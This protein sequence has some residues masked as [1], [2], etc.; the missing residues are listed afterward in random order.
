MSAAAA[1]PGGKTE[2][3]HHVD[4]RQESPDTDSLGRHDAADRDLWRLAFEHADSPIVVVDVDGTVVHANAAAKR[5]ARAS[6]SS[7]VMG[8]PFLEL[9][10]AEYRPAASEAWKQHAARRSAAMGDHESI[11]SVIGAPNFGVSI[12]PLPG[13][14]LF[15][16]TLFSAGKLAAPDLITNHP[17][18][19]SVVNE[20]SQL[21]SQ[22][23]DL[24]QRLQLALEKSLAALRMDAGAIALVDGESRDLVIRAHQ[25][26]EH[27]DLAAR[28]QYIALD[29]SIW[30]QTVHS[31]QVVV[32]DQ[33]TTDT[34]IEPQ[35][36]RDE[37]VD[38]IALAPMF[39]RGQVVGVL[40]VMH[41]QPYTFSPGDRHLLSVVADRVGLAVDNARLYT[42]I[43]RRLQEQSA[44]H[45]IALATQGVLSLQT[46]MDQGLRA[47]TA[48]FNLDAAAVSLL[49]THDRLIPV[50]IHG[51]ETG[52]WD[53][54]QRRRPHLGDTL[55]G[56][57]TTQ[58]RSLIVQNVATS[59]DM[60][61]DDFVAT[62][63]NSVA[64]V[65]LV[66][67][68]RLIGTLEMG[69]KRANALTP[70]DIPLLE[71]LAAQLASAI[72]AARLYEQTERRVDNLTTLTQISA[73]VNR[74][75]NL[76]GILNVVLDETLA[77]VNP[78]TDAPKGAIL[79]V[80]PNSAG[81][82]V[83]VARN[84]D[85]GE[86]LAELLAAT[87]I[88]GLVVRP[89]TLLRDLLAECEIRAYAP[90]AEAS[91]S[92]LWPGEP[93][94]AI[95]MCLDDRSIGTI[96]AIGQPTSGEMERLLEAV[97]DLA[98]VA[99]DKANL[100]EETRR[101]LDEVSLLHE[102]G[103]AAASALDHTA[104]AS[105]AL[106]ALE[107]TSGFE[108]AS[109]LL[110]AADA[111]HLEIVASSFDGT[112]G[113][114]QRALRIGEGITGQTALTGR[115]IL[116]SDVTLVENYIPVFPK[117]RSVLCVPLKFGGRVIGVLKVESTQLNAFGSDDQH[118]L[119]T[120]AGQLAVGIENARLHHETQQRLR[121]MTTLFN[122][123]HALST[124]LHLEDLLD[125]VTISIREVLGCRGV[126][127]ALLD[128]ENQ[129]LEIK[130]A[131]GLKR[132]LR[133]QVRMSVGE[134]VMGTVAATGHSVYV[135]DV[136]ELDDFI[137]FDHSFHSLLTVPLLV[138]NRVIGTLS[139]DH[140]RRDAFS[141]D[142][143]QLVTIAASQA[144]VAIENAR[145]FE[146]L[147]N[148]A[149]SLAQA[150][151]ELKEIDRMKDELAQNISHELR[152]PLTFVRGYVD[153]LLGGDMGPLNARQQQSLEVVSQKT[154]TVAELVN[155]IILL[156]QL[157]HSPL[158]LALTDVSRVAK[159]AVARIQTAAAHQGVSLSLNVPSQLPL[160]LVDPVRIKLVFQH[161]I[162]N[163]IKFSPNGGM[164][165]V[166]LSEE[167][168]SLNISVRDE[169]IGIS[170]DQ[171]DHIFDRFFQV[172][173]SAKRR[174][175]GAGL[176]LTIAK[177]IV[178]AHGGSIWVKSRVGKG[179]EF[180]FDI[181]KSRRVRDQGPGAS[182]E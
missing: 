163:A 93:L 131:A 70:D 135:P 19:L 109:V 43:Q 1:P 95:P 36:L 39:A 179:S 134:G 10:P 29:S 103:L 74:T 143:E 59:K 21:V 162:D 144:A 94:V 61:P 115:P 151:E 6:P 101:R 132:E 66:V 140:E 24:D 126:S 77:L 108:Y 17:L 49:D 96:I 175:E 55:T 45:E 146:D 145:L 177:R 89:G 133:S 123:A 12:K 67:R 170:Q 171:L 113:G 18:E 124:H 136:H 119:T 147:Q 164:V 22:T 63:L 97:A 141:S 160:V 28:A 47:V 120:V 180:G 173:S 114:H 168:E 76:D 172:D 137:F 60:V 42:R 30:S 100:H 37:G 71:S 9:I 26:W 27:H 5:H 174:F 110:V 84:L 41:H 83:A 7:A 105:R 87:P 106:Q 65:R 82:R 157:E 118:L 182:D 155:N 34:Q 88:D 44:L 56:R 85:E 130:A 176:G 121:E 128:D 156:Q 169:G 150:Y 33:S 4:S 181:P 112:D 15:L 161:L 72:D 31:R 102:V 52:Y 51:S 122:F 25:G 125:T 92:M 166:Q 64:A 50:A 13:H 117:V 158:Q 104:I 11:D 68:S 62:G 178:E 32:V 40:S 167:S 14:P 90:L 69:A 107:R 86:L 111:K 73:A 159:E 91:L 116:V 8:Q 23:L 54:L 127:I 16:V 78:V 2:A 139:I 3:A 148:R 142:D 75:L 53:Q 48:L 57:S 153:L 165:Q 35:E 20:I 81:I 154:A 152:T 58:S 98:A 129:Q 38:A 99:I 46:V 138:K 80:D 149:T 79:L